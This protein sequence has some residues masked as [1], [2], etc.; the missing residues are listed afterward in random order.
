MI[1]STATF[2]FQHWANTSP[3]WFWHSP[4]FENI[5]FKWA[6]NCL[7]DMTKSSSYPWHFILKIYQNTFQTLIVKN[8]NLLQ[9]LWLRSGFRRENPNLLSYIHLLSTLRKQP[10]VLPIQM[11]NWTIFSPWLGRIFYWTDWND[12]MFWQPM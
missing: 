1:P 2:I 11:I 10:I 4:N 8:H 9:E 5:E 7:R 6:Q 3:S 12:Q